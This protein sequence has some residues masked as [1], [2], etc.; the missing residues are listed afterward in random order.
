MPV[1]LAFG[2]AYAHAQNNVCQT[3]DHMVTVRGERSLH[4]GGNG[5]GVLGVRTLPTR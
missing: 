1:A 4:F 3:A 2:A 5:T